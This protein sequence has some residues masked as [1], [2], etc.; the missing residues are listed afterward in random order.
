MR[1]NREANDL[2]QQESHGSLL[3]EMKF[4]PPKPGSRNRILAMRP[5]F[6]VE[7]RVSWWLCWIAHDRK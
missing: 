1:R 2:E 3:A 6:I 4:E 7:E 5:I